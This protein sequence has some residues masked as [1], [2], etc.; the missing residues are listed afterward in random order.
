[1]CKVWGFVKYHTPDLIDFDKELFSLLCFAKT[2]VDNRD[3]DMRLSQWVHKI[4]K[5]NTI[6]ETEFVCD[7]C[8]FQISFDWIKDTTLFSLQLIEE[9]SVTKKSIFDTSQYVCWDKWITPKFDGERKYET[10]T[11]PNTELCLLV[12]FRYWNIIEYYYPYRYSIA[13][14]DKVLKD[15]IPKFLSVKN[16]LELLL[17][18][19]LLITCIKDGHAM[20]SRLEDNTLMRQHFGDKV[21]PVI[22][23]KIQD[24]YFIVDYMDSLAGRETKLR[25]GDEILKI[26]NI[27]ID[28]LIQSKLPYICGSNMSSRINEA[29]V[30]ILTTFVKEAHI[31]YCRGRDTTTILVKTSLHDS[32]NYRL[33]DEKKY[34]SIPNPY[35]LQKDVGYLSLKDLTDSEVVAAIVKFQDTKAI[36]ID[37]RYYPHKSRVILYTKYLIDAVN[38]F[39]IHTVPDHSCPGCFVFTDSKIQTMETPVY[40]GKIYVI[41]NYETVS[42]GEL[43]TMALQS[44]PNT[45]VIG[46]QTAGT[47]GSASYIPLPF[48]IIVAISGSGVYYPDGTETQHAGIKI[49]YEVY[50]DIQD[51]QEGKDTYIKKALELI[52]KQ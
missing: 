48:N 15:F 27:P 36:I 30:A 12:L 29:L 6:A 2:S 4:N 49:D 40:K 34:S 22:I 21:I 11:L 37:L 46:N 35:F 45:I 16:R 9:L 47:D 26:Y 25:K 44:N 39:F 31:T 51:I 18:L 14:W 20:I 7:S 13:D 23:E 8:V 52:N 42:A 1:V 5:H 10:E 19:Q 28:S 33:Y 3:F 24:K 32:V 38:P 17:N 41:V 43:T 50:P